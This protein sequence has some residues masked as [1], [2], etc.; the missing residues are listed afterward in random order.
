MLGELVRLA[1]GSQVKS[2]YLTQ[3]TRY[4][5]V[6]PTIL[7]STISLTSYSISWLLTMIGGGGGCIW[8]SGGLVVAGSRRD[9]CKTGCIIIEVG[10]SSL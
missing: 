9:I 2:E 8:S 5:K 3:D 7:E 4:F 1:V 10:R 6:F